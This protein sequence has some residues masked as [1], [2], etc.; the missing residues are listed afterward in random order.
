[1]HRGTPARQ[2]D[3]VLRIHRSLRRG[4]RAV[5][6]DQRGI[7]IVR[8]LILMHNDPDPD[9]MASAVEWV[10]THPDRAITYAECAR[11]LTGRFT[12][13]AVRDAWAALYRSTDRN[14]FNPSCVSHQPLH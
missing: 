7:D 5:E 12:W 13:P 10:L 2:P 1:M 6:D 14:P 3:L 4:A 11:A 9:A 8:V